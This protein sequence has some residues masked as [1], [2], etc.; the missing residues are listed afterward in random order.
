MFISALLSVIACS[1]KTWS[2]FDTDDADLTINLEIGLWGYHLHVESLGQKE[3][4]DGEWDDDSM[5][6]QAP[7]NRAATLMASFIPLFACCFFLYL[8]MMKKRKPPAELGLGVACL[9]VA[10]FE[11]IAAFVWIDDAEI[12][13]L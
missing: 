1:I 11:L 3:D 7:V 5:P 2:K 4:D 13:S 8:A 9:V 10:I 12:V 6:D